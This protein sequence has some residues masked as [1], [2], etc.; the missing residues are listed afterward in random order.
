MNPLMLRQIW[1]LIEK[2]Q[3]NVLLSLDD[4]SLVQWLLKQFRQ[5]QPLD[6]DQVNVL[7]AYLRSRL[8]LIRDIA[9]ERIATDMG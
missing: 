9:S 2:T 8:S 1:S 5:E 4:A 3:V 6:P 7:N